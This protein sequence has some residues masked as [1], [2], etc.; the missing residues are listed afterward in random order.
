MNKYRI[1]Y[2]NNFDGSRFMNKKILFKYKYKKFYKRKD[3]EW[4]AYCRT[5]ILNMPEE[6][7]D[8]IKKKKNLYY[9]NVFM[10][11]G[12]NTSF[13]SFW[14]NDTT[15]NIEFEAENDEEALLRME[16]ER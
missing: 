10:N 5:E 4:N 7:N 2:C 11:T 14:D 6:Y 1:W 9:I 3:S 8:M 16:L 15:D 13:V 12:P